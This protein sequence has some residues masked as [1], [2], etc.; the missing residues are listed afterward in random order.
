MIYNLKYLVAIN[1][2]ISDDKVYEWL[3]IFNLFDK[4]DVKVRKFSLGMR[5][6]LALCQEFMENPAIICDSFPY[7]SLS[8]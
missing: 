1:K 8:L 3:K 2:I 4:K 7:F 6:R 5:Q